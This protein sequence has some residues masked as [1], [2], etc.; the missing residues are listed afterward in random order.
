MALGPQSDL[1]DARWTAQC[2][3]PP[4][5]LAGTS[6]P[7]DVPI[8]AIVLERQGRLHRHCA[9]NQATTKLATQ[10]IRPSQPLA[11]G[12]AVSARH[13]GSL[14]TGWHD[15]QSQTHFVSCDRQ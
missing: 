9:I 10:S 6:L 3:L 4:Q 1:L 12:D 11:V 13:E 8:L 14:L 7:L 5:T 2:D 15:G